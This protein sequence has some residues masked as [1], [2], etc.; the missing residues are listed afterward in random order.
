MSYIHIY[1]YTH[2]HV[3]IIHVLMRTRLH[4]VNNNNNI[5]IIIIVDSSSGIAGSKTTVV[6]QT[7]GRIGNSDP[8]GDA[9]SWRFNRILAYEAHRRGFAVLEREELERRLQYKSEY[10]PDFKYDQF[11]MHSVAI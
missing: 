11:I 5:I 8:H 4:S 6:I 7:A 10:H 9:C 2:I 3:H 1:L